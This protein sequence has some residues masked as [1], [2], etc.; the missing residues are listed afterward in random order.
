MGKELKAK[1][2]LDVK[3]ATKQ[4][5]LLA[6]KIN[7]INRSVNQISNGN[8]GLSK[9]IKQATTAT[10][11]LSSQLNRVNRANNQAAR[12]ANNISKGYKNA[13]SAVSVL[14]KNLRA[15][16]STYIGI[17]GAKAVLGVSDRITSAENRLNALPEN[18]QNN[19]P[20]TMDKV[21][22][23]AQRSR[24]GYSDML[25]N[26]SKSMTLAPDAFQ[27][28]IDNAIRFQEI[29]AET[30]ALGGASAAEQSSSLYQMM[31]ALGSGVLQGDELRSVREG[32]PLAYQAIEKFAQGIY[33]AEEN[34][35]DLASEGKITSDIVVAAMM[36]MGDEIDSKFA[37]TSMTFAQ[38]GEMLKNTATKAFEPVLQ[39]LNDALNSDMGKAILDGL[40]QALV[41]LANIVLWVGSIFEQFFIW[42]NDNWYWLQ[43]IVYGVIAAIVIYLGI[44]AAKAIWTGITAF[45]SFITGMSPLYMWIIVIG[46]VV[47]AIVWL[48]N[49]TGS[50]CQAI[51]QV[52]MW[53]AIAIVAILAIVLV[54]YI[55]TGTIMLSIPMLI[56]LMIVAVIA[57]VLAVFLTFTGEIIGGVYGIGSVIKF[58]WNNI[59]TIMKDTWYGA[60]A[61]FWDFIANCAEGLNWLA[62]PL[63]KIA[64]LFG[65][66]F[67]YEDF[68]ADIRSKA[69]AS[70]SKLSG[71]DWGSGIKDAWG[72]AY[73]EGYSVGEGIQNKI[74]GFGDK[75][76][77]FNLS[78]T[79]ANSIPGLSGTG[80]P[81]PN[82]PNLDVSGA[83][84][85][86]GIGKNIGKTADNTG[87]MADSMEMTQEDL[88]YLRKVADMEW[89]KEFTT[90]NITVDMSNYNTI[91]GD[92]D[93]DGIVTK[94]SDR[95]YEE[96]DALANGVYV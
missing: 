94:L 42:I 39:S 61:D 84:D 67:S 53:V 34:L 28:N 50:L 80:L 32:A 21:Y 55:A 71:T 2:T 83:Y 70:R 5:D 87:K 36:K 62:K 86:S 35:K 11:Q 22:A 1:V 16:A 3:G 68:V 72:S 74:N 17:M 40:S 14:T 30:Y 52:A 44:M 82:A 79:I 15:L 51:V 81:D 6:K 64:E 19:T 25:G 49:T 4:L 33:G 59:G 45:W 92:G 43:Y 47:A 41:G 9:L 46:M 37:E 69:D 95:L 89:K 58:V 77:N 90:A 73:N 31:Q 65:K 48:A 60:I 57:L 54:V 78:N 85:P 76:K 91:N 24:S 27:G 96:M 93:L 13:N 66:S 75:L 38:A 23:A 20:E 18:Y 8:G 29:M 10:N 56:G 63:S 88:E 7:A 12:S 26:V